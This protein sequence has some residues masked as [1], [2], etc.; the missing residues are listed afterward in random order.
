MAIR[1]TMQDLVDRLATLL[2]DSANATWT[3]D[4]LQAELDRNRQRLNFALMEPEVSYD[5]SGNQQYLT[6][7][8]PHGDLEDGATYHDGGKSAIT[9]STADFVAGRVVF[10]S[11]EEPA[12]PVYIVGWAYDLY[13]AAA[14]LIEQHLITLAGAYDFSADGGSYKRSQQYTMYEKLAGRYGRMAKGWSA[15]SSDGV[16]FVEL[17]RGDLN[18]W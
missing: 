11:S 2:N 3:E 15:N 7:S 9:A 16:Q 8:S 5:D 4:A 12:R 6:F 17:V 18:V 14:A 13:G 1:A 10:S